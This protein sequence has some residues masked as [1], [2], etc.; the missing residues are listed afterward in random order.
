MILS[1]FN[2]RSSI[3]E[4]P[5]VL[6]KCPEIFLALIVAVIAF[7]GFLNLASAGTPQS[8]ATILVPISGVSSKDIILD[9]SPET[10]EFIKGATNINYEDFLENG[11]NLKPVPDIS[12]ILGAAGISRQDSVVITGECLPCGGGPAPATYTYW[13]LKYLGHDEVRVLDGGIKDWKAAG[14]PISNESSIR[15]ATS[16]M[17]ETKAEL[18]ATYDY[19][20]NSGAQIVD[21]RSTQE[22]ALGSI[23]GA[24]NVPMENVLD[25]ESIRNK[26]KLE[27]AFSDLKKDK[28]VVVFTNIGVQAS[29]LWFALTLSGYDARLL[30]LAGLAGKPTQI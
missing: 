17:P 16:Y 2:D 10:D 1:Q 5:G 6:K 19:V 18:L 27:E 11:G 24:I 30:L 3:L 7:S 20:L 15:P 9:I 25:N 26:A 13:L 28:P 4:A 8:N 21:G 14:L 29:V 22:Y 12:R 23:P